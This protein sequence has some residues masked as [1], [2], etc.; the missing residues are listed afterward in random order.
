MAMADDEAELARL[1]R[2]VRATI[3]AR[4]DLESGLANPEALRSAIA[5]AYRDRD[6]VTSPL[7]EEAREKVAADIEEFHKQWRH[8]DKIARSVERLNDLLV[9]AP[10]HVLGHRD[11]VVAALPGVREQRTRVSREI[12]AAGLASILPEEDTTDG[13]R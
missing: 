8:V 1:Q 2:E 13:E 10:A 4:T 6:A 3:K 12:A 7:L 5:R 11:A 9:D